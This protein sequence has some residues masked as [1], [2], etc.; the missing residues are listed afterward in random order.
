MVSKIKFEEIWN[1]SLQDEKL[2]VN[3]AFVLAFMLK[4][5]DSRLRI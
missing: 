3:E 2:K 4:N 5:A 1:P